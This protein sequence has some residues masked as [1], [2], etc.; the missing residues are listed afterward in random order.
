MSL[1]AYKKLL[2]WPSTKLQIKTKFGWR[3]SM[4]RW[5]GVCSYD[6]GDTGVVKCLCQ[7]NFLVHRL[8]QHRARHG[9]CSELCTG[10]T[11]ALYRSKSL[12]P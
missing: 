3:D 5:N 9:C 4:V 1:D 6:A 8:C 10:D 11:C 7:L 12:G 2:A